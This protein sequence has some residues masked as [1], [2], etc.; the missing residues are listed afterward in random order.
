MIFR[1]ASMQKLLL[2]ATMVYLYL[3]ILKF[4]ADYSSDF[5]DAMLI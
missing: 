4:N 1:Q 3:S 2:E 5:D